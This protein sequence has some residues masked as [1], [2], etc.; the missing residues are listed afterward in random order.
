[1][2]FY[3]ENV[4]K[5]K[6]VYCLLAFVHFCI[7]IIYIYLLINNTIIYGYKY[8]LIFYVKCKIT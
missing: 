3:D 4:N 5:N 8:V 1:M 7:Y 2:F 6:N